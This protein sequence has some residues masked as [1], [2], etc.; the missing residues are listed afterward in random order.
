MLKEALADPVRRSTLGMAARIRH[1]AQR[2]RLLEAQKLDLRSEILVRYANF[3]EQIFLDSIP[4]S[5]P[6]YNALVLGMVGD[7]HRFDDPRTLAKL[8]GSEVNHY[9]SGD[10]DGT[11]RISHRGRSPLRAAAYQQA[12]FLVHRNPDFQARFH[13][14]LHRTDRPSL[15]DLPAYVAVMNSYLRIAHVLVTRRQFYIPLAERTAMDHA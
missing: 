7:F 6:F 11:S 9:Y 13:H 3:E 4:G 14:L 12:R 15:R 1:T 5:D 10:W 2:R 8:A